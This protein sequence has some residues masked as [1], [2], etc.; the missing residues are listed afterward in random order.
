VA[1]KTPEKI[2]KTLSFAAFLL[3]AIPAIVHFT[4]QVLGTLLLRA[5]A[6][7]INGVI[8][9]RPDLDEARKAMQTNLFL[10]IPI[11]CNTVILVAA[12]LWTTRISDGLSVLY[13]AMLVAGQVVMWKICRPIE[14]RFKAMTVESDDPDIA[15]EFKHYVQMW[16]GFHLFLKPPKRA[17]SYQKE[18]SGK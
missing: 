4:I 14:Q 9:S 5:A 15:T 8:R 1:Q 2:M 13:I 3:L 16:S 7:N 18:S 10:G 11:L 6:E 12:L 17:D